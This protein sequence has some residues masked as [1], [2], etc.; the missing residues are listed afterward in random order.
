MSGLTL[1]PKTADV[2]SPLWTTRGRYKAAWGG[3]GSAKSNDRAQAVV[4]RMAT[5][6]GSRIVCL[7]EVQNS[8]KD[9]VY[10]LICDWIERLG[11]GSMFDII[12]EEIRGPGGSLCI[13]RG[14]RDQN[15]ES[16][17]SLEG[18][19]VAWFEEAQTCSQRSLDILRPTIRAPGSELWFTWNPKARTDPVDIFFRQKPPHDAIVV[20]ANYY[21]N[22]WFP[23]ELEG[24][25][26]IDEQGDEARYRNIW[27]GDYEDQS[28][29]QLI[30][31]K[32]VD[33]ASKAK[34]VMHP[35]DE[36][37]MAVDVARYGD[38][39]TIICFRKG[40]DAYSEPWVAMAKLDTMEVAARVASHFDRVKPDALFVDETGVGA[41]VV[42]RLKQL[43]YPVAPVNFGSKPDGMTEAKVANKRAEMWVR[44]R[45]WLNGGAIPDDT[46][47]AAQLTAVEYKH[48]ANN[49]ILLEKKEDMKRRGLPSPDRADALAITFAYPVM[50]SADTWNNDH[51]HYGR[52]EAT[53]Y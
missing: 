22:P 49:A 1:Q 26:L 48:D 45:E 40:R 17:K 6:P 24:E 10:Q 46:Q 18:Y 30:S 28:D 3:R 12:R 8:I 5:E 4:L 50:K 42:D 23:A 32:I 29:K 11:L 15:A 16:I 39:E 43:G 2:F 41:G 19:T 33:Q 35:A 13:F 52:S 9:S 20:K 31:A 21:D 7:R 44:M 14:M 47:L 38:D 36:M 27:L 53:G 51:G 34:P 25:R 37:I